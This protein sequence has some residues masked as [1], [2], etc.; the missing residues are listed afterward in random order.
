MGRPRVSDPQGVVRFVYVTD[1]NVSRDPGEVLRVLADLQ[2][3]L[4]S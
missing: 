1:P 3:S 2:E 4:P